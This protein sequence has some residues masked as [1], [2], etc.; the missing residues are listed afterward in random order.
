MDCKKD[1]TEND[2]PTMSRTPGWEERKVYTIGCFDLFHRG[3][4]NVLESL[5]EFGLYIVAGIHDDASYFKLKK[6]MPIDNLEK[7]MENVKPYVDQIYVIPSTDPG[8][9]IKA[10]VSEADIEQGQCCYARGDDMLQFPS[11]PWVESKMPIHF[12]PRTESC[13]SSLIRT[14]YHS[15][16]S[17]VGATAAFAKTNSDGKPIDKDGNVIKIVPVA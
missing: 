2:L 16:D 10:M 4:G 12:V 14:I 11:R 6:K 9:Y 8:P 15:G 5:R 1:N 7:R 13:S 3:H 17:S